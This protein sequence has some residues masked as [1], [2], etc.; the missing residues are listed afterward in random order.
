[1]RR[2]IDPARFPALTS[3]VDAGVFD[4]SDENP[5]AEFHSG[6]AQLL[7]GVAARIGQSGP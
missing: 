6:V 5:L 4:G 1:L 7:D 2:L 3:A